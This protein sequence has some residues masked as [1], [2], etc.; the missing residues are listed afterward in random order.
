MCIPERPSHTQTPV[1]YQNARHVAGAPRLKA[2]ASARGSSAAGE[3]LRVLDCP[4]VCEVCLSGFRLP[5]ICP[6]CVQ[7]SMP[8]PPASRIYVCA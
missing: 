3:D 8:P 1:I 2:E 4:F 7:Q 6:L 5:S